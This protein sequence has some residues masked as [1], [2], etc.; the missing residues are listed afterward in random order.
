[1]D[2]LKFQLNKVRRL[3]N[4]QGQEFKFNRVKANEFG[5]PNGQPEVIAITGVYHETTS[6]LSKVSSDSTTVRQKPSPMI[7]CLWEDAKKLKHTDTLTFNS[8]TYTI[9]DIKNVSE[10]SVVGDISLEEVQNG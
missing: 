6:F 5:E 7:L 4:T 3:I 10:A 8:K 2:A 1:M 9:G